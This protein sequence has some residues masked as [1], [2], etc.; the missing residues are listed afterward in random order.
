MLFTAQTYADRGAGSTQQAIERLAPL[1]RHHGAPWCAA[2]SCPLWL[3][4]S[5]LA[6]NADQLL[7]QTLRPQLKRLLMLK[8]GCSIHAD[9]DAGTIRKC[10][11]DVPASRWAAVRARHPVCQREAAVGSRCERN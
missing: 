11:P 9:L 5:L 2:P 7:L 3:S 6:D 4:A 8:A 1:A 10:V